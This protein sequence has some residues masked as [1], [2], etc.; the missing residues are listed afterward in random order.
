MT[1]KELLTSKTFQEIPDDTEIWLNSS[2]F[3]R[4]VESIEKRKLWIGNE[5]KEVLTIHPSSKGYGIINCM[6]ICF[7]AVD[8]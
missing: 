3:Y 5:R 1:K 8:N 6:D 4:K 2:C 7:F